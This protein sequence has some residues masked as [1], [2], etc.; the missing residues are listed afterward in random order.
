[1]EGKRVSDLIAV[2]ADL[3]TEQALHGILLRRKSLGI[4]PITHKI[5]RYVRR[6]AG[7]YRQGHDYLRPFTRQFAYA[8]VLFDRHGCGGERKPRDALEGDLEE[9]L[10]RNGWRG[11]AAAIAIDPELEAW[12]WSTSPEVAQVLGWRG[13]IADLYRWLEERSLMTAGATKPDD[14]KM[15]LRKA[16]REVGKRAS[17]AIFRQLAERVS[18]DRCTDAAFVKL[19]ETLRRWFP[20]VDPSEDKA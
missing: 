9:R 4:R 16:L 18:L 17:P 2:V 19:K 3:D 5:D 12:A 8:L 15:A 6:D 7:C 14:P 11:R 1:M 20:A 13:T 10:S